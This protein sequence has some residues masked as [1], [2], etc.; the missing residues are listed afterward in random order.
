MTPSSIC[1]YDTRNVT[2]QVITSPHITS[3]GYQYAGHQALNAYHHHAR[4]H[5][6][7]KQTPIDSMPVRY[8]RL[9]VNVNDNNINFMQLI[10]QYVAILSLPHLHFL[11]NQKSFGN[12]L[13]I[14]LA[15]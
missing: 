4:L 11:I 13:K 10:T 1:A 15:F 12:Q 14:K 8:N 3:V 2:K 6:W 7:Y 5:P 9:S